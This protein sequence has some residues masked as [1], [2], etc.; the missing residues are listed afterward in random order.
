MARWHSRDTD[1]L[2][3]VGKI[4]K[5]SQKKT[6]AVSKGETFERPEV[7]WAVGG[8][9]GAFAARVVEVHKRYAFIS[10]EHEVNA[11]DTRDVWLAEVARRFL[12]S[13]RLERNFIAVGDRVLCVPDREKLVK[14]ASDL[15]KCVIQHRT[16]RR[17]RIARLDPQTASREHVL[18]T[19]MDQVLIVASFLSPKV[20]WGLIDRYLVLAESEAVDAIIVL[21]K[22]DLLTEEG[23]P[24]DIR[25]AEA[26]VALYRGLGYQVVTV[27]ANADTAR[28]HPEIVRLKALLEGKITL[29]SGH[30]GVGK[31]SLVNLFKPEIIQTV[32]EDDNIFYK[33]RHTTSFA[34]FIKLGTG[35]Y[36]IDTPGI[37]S[38][39]FEEKTAIEL[40]HCFVEFR[41]LLGKCKYRECRHMDEPECKVLAAVA[42]GTISRWRYKSY[43]GILLGATGR[44]GRIRDL[45]LDERDIRDLQPDERDIR[46]LLLNEQA[47]RE[48]G[49]LAA[50]MSS[51]DLCIDEPEPEPG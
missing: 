37:R 49:Q 35:G 23:R 27:Q 2:E 39:T 40:S 51:D 13:D 31:S 9:D 36:V 32:E 29:L 19:N 34:S 25:E 4:R 15:P 20:K 10:T 11:V 28:Q 21:N 7:K 46:D 48:L 50:P 14:V 30:S 5:K 33:G 8:D 41:P 38:F 26:M 3:K 44:E 24:E 18:A 47:I 17:S 45:P 12:V 42:A 22:L 43:L 1:L 16:P 6:H